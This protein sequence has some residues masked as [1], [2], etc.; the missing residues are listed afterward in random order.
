MLTSVKPKLR[1]IILMVDDEPWDKKIGYR[2]QK[3]LVKEKLNHQ[4]NKRK[5]KH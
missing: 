3:N 1:H 2:D 5:Q 4:T